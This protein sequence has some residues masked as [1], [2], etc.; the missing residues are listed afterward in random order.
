ME[1]LKSGINIQI[2]MIYVNDYNKAALKILPH[3]SF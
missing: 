1:L 2:Y 3:H